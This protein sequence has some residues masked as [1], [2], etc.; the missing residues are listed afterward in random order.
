MYG[1]ARDIQNNIYAAS[2]SPKNIYRS[3][4]G[5]ENWDT[6][7]LGTPSN[8]L[9][10]DVDSMLNIYIPNQSNGMFKTTNGG[11]NWTQLPTSAFNGRSLQ[12]ICCGKNGYIYAGTTNGGVYRSTDYGA[13]FPDSGIQGVTVVMIK[14]DR[15]NSNIVYACGS[16]AGTNNGFYYSTD[17]GLTW[18]A[19]TNP[20][21]HY[22]MTQANN[23]DVYTVSTST[24]YP[25]SK[26]T[27]NGA[28]WTVVYNFAGAQRGICIDLIGNFYTA[29][30]GGVFRS[31][32]GGTSF[33]NFNVTYSSNRLLSFQN[34]ILLAVSGTTNG[35]V[36]I[37]T[38][39]TISNSNPVRI[40]VPSDYFLS[41]NFPNPFNPVTR[42]TFSIPK[43]KFITLKIFDITGREIQTL[44]SEMK[45]GGTHTLEFKA[46]NL[47]SGVYF[48]KLE[49]DGFSEVKSMI[50]LK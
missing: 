50:L 7:F 16:G 29:G 36:Y 11:L 49:C 1:F 35:G 9:N 43:D 15:F 10:I 30:N 33:V 44:I 42:I 5:G 32:D 3:S 18:S 34:K 2:I 38:D 4:D 40:P 37:Y 25:L 13:T 39:T 21:N 19:N 27:N 12:S 8:A 14:V 22:D 20:I 48:Y 26:S 46:G 17:A 47:S 28:N 31:T 24:G 41:Q 45:Q 23:G 6:I